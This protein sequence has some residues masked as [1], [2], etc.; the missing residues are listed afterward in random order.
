MVAH[1]EQFEF[2]QHVQSLFPERF[3]SQRVLEVGSL[4]IN[5][6]VRSFF[7]N[8]DYIGIDIA[9]GKGVDIVCEGQRYDA[10]D[11]SFDM[12]ISC[13]AMEHNPF[14][15]ETLDNMIRLVRPGGLVVMTC[16]TLGREEHGTAASEPSSSPLTVEKGWNY[17]R[18]LTPSDLKEVPGL[19]LLAG[20]GHASNWDS[21]DLYFVGI[22]TPAQNDSLDRLNKLFSF[23]RKRFWTTLKWIRR[24]PRKYLIHMFF[25]K[26]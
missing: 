20:W 11:A 21:F 13:E 8:C 25:G 1:R 6:S 19:K 23:Y 5:G 12:V 10:P 14:W 16:A 3:T 9:E 18:N 22:K 24:A 2:I 15:K 26:K 17:Y 4:D 7:T